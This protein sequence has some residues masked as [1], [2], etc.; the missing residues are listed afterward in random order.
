M[1]QCALGMNPLYLFTQKIEAIILNLEIQW[2]LLL[3]NLFS[4]QKTSP[5]K[6]EKDVSVITIWT[7][8]YAWFKFRRLGLSFNLNELIF[9]I[10]S[11]WKW[12][13]TSKSCYSC[14]H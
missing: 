11:N 6:E 2:V 4:S 8:I 3:E 10:V 13:E 9:E 5:I 12:A 1:I 14:I 7:T